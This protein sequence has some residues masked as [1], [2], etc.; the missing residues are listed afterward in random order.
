MIWDFRNKLLRRAEIKERI[1]ERLRASKHRKGAFEE[2]SFIDRRRACTGPIM[3]PLPRLRYRPYEYRPYE[4]MPYEYG[5]PYM[6]R[7][8]EYRPY[9]YRPYEYRPVPVPPPPPPVSIARRYRISPRHAVRRS[10]PLRRP[11]LVRPRLERE[12]GHIL[13]NHINR[14]KL[15]RR[16]LISREGWVSK[17]S[18]VDERLERIRERIRAIRERRLGL[19]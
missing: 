19:R 15:G 14:D 17:R 1:R 13:K 12:A 6:Y 7:P 4:Y 5:P 16:P 2:G 3:R 10:V 18:D 9:E 11:S 8:Y